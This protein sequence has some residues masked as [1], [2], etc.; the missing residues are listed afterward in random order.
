[1]GVDILATRNFFVHIG[2][3]MAASL[4]CFVVALVLDR[5]AKG[6]ADAP[7]PLEQTGRRG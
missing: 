4:A 3:L 2:E 6:T 7:G 5:T 1:M